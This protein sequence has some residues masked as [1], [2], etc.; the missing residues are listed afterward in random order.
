LLYRQQ[1]NSEPEYQ[2]LPS[3]ETEALYALYNATNGQH[4]SWLNASHGVPWVF[5]ATSNPCTGNW[6]GVECPLTPPYNV[7]TITLADQQLQGTL[8]SEIGNFTKLQSLHIAHSKDLTGTLPESLG[9]LTQLESLVISR[10]SLTGTVP[11]VVSNLTNL[12]SLGFFG[13]N[14]HGT[15][16]AEVCTM[17]SL[18][19]LDLSFNEMTGSMPPC[20]CNLTNLSKGLALA[21]NYLTGTIPSCFGNLTQLHALDIFAN[22]FTGTIP[23]SLGNMT[24]LWYMFI[25]HNRLSGPLPASFGYLAEFIGLFAYTNTLSGTI[26]QSYERLRNLR[27]LDINANL[28]SGTFPAFLHNLTALVDF[29]AY[30]SKLSGTIPPSLTQLHHLSFLEV[31]DCYLTGSLPAGIGALSA[32]QYL[33]AYNNAL[34]GTIP[35]SVVNMSQLLSFELSNNSLTGS[36][37]ADLGKLEQLQ[38]VWLDHNLLD[39][40]IPRS[41]SSIPALSELFLSNNRLTG[42]L[43]DVFDPLTQTLLQTVQLSGNQLTGSLPQKIYA[44]PALTTFAAVS[45]C[46]VT[47]L[48]EEVCACATLVT[49]ALDGLQSSSKCQQKLLAGLSDSYLVAQPMKGGIPACIFAMPL[50][51]TLHLSGNGLSGSLPP[52]L[53]VSESL[54]DL[55]LSHNGLTGTIPPQIQERQWY[56]LDLSFN[57]LTGTLSPRF[58]S[59]TLNYSQYVQFVNASDPSQRVAVT[60]LN[61]RLSGEIPGALHSLLNVSVLGSNMFSCDVTGSSLPAH[62]SGS[63]KYSCGSDGFNTPYYVW[64]GLVLGVTAMCVISMRSG[65]ASC[66]SWY[67]RAVGYLKVV[68]GSEETDQVTARVPSLAAVMFVL[69]STCTLTSTAVVFILVALLPLYVGLSYRA[70]TFTYMYAWGTSAAFLSGRLATGLVTVFLLALLFL[71][72]GLAYRRSVKSDRCKR[73]LSYRAPLRVPA[74]DTT[75]AETFQRVAAYTLF[76][77]SSFSVVVGVNIAY[78]YVALYATNRVLLLSQILLSFFKLFWNSFGVR[79]LMRWTASIVDQSTDESAF[80]RGKDLMFVL[81]LVALVN[82]IGI[83]CL[84]VA[85]VSPSCFYN[86]FVAA[87]SIDASYTYV[88]CALIDDLN[89]DCL[90]SPPVLGGTTYNPPFSYSYQCSSSFVTY[91]APA[92]VFLCITATILTPLSEGLA[93]WAHSS[94]PK[95]A[96]SL[97]SVLLTFL[98]RILRPLEPDASSVKRDTFHPYFDANRRIVTLFSYLGVLVTFG[99]VF[100]PLG[101]AVAVTVYVSALMEKLKLGRFLSL[102]H[103]LGS[104]AHADILEAECRGTGGAE[105]L[106]MAVRMIASFSCWFYTLFLFDTLGDAVGIEKAYWVLIV[107]PLLPVLVYMAEVAFVR[108]RYRKP[109]PRAES[110]ASNATLAMTMSPLGPHVQQPVERVGEEVA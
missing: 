30:K 106:L 9:R 11:S 7:I 35:I 60:L 37:P 19:G 69:E 94:W 26:P 61:N 50:L 98:P 31:Y 39:G 70:G 44:L 29:A 64:L 2:N 13:N 78:V 59:Q 4:W 43:D 85:V 22:E 63:D 36:I 99:A 92:F 75:A 47:T 107:I 97:H 3:S 67:N 6:Q 20:L 18:Y 38:Y 34:T 102:A 42:T 57:R 40:A 91:Y 49:L 12:R 1:E 108:V 48:N 33:E 24:Q 105:V 14:L 17:T 65:D 83:P 109:D 103:E 68:G 74:A 8:P 46:F 25:F 54:V 10:N 79:Y 100:P 73:P 51:N 5:D 56:N 15:I 21:D 66:G 72:L 84:V 90:V 82:N 104:T 110:T 77:A 71:L 81:L 89:G 27:T 87:P 80:L 52:D 93:L 41:L 16:P 32:M 55:S 28:I 58:A 62:D 86:V 101:V 76:M 23:E 96:G 45:N 53:V 95:G 88:Y